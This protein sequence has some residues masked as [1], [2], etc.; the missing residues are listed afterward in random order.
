MGLQDKNRWGVKRLLR[1]FV[2]ACSGLKYVYKNE[3]NI[4][5]HLVF[6]FLILF[7]ACLLS[8]SLTQ[9]L[10]LIV[11]IGIVLALEVMNTAIERTVDLITDEFHPLAKLAKDI[12]AAAVFV[13]SLVAVIIGLIIFLPILIDLIWVS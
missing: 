10:I 12:S 3:Q 13:F 9:L 2:F 8:V 1:S 11:V 6:A 5:I 4:R 7:F